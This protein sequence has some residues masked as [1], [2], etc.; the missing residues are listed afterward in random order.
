MPAKKYHTA[1]ERK[2][3]QRE[4][5]Q[6]W[7]AKARAHRA[8]YQKAWRDKNID[9]VLAYD[10]ARYVEKGDEIR[11]KSRRAT[12]ARYHEMKAQVHAAYGGKCACCGESAPEFLTVDHVGGRDGD[13]VGLTS[14]QVFAAIIR[15]GFPD[16]YRLLCWNCNMSHGLHGY[17]PHERLRVIDGGHS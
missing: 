1:E 7:R 3:A 8:A 15:E 13:H 6:R 16:K 10:A 9:H 14:T 5:A 11:E 17:C 2:A 4:A 12:L